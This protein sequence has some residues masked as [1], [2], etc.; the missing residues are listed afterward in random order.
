MAKT[1]KAEQEEPLEKKLWKAADKLRVE[2][3]FNDIGDSLQLSP[4][5]AD[6]RLIESVEVQGNRRLKSERVLGWIQTR[7]GDIHKSEQ[8]K[9]DLEAVPRIAQGSDFS[10]S[11]AERSVLHESL[12]GGSPDEEAFR[13]DSDT[14]DAGSLP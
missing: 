14:A 1:I 4:E 6:G 5:Q 8:V 13:P 9:R 11:R 7:A 2:Y 10:T 3:N 12:A